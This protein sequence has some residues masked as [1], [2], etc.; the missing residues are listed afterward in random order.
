MATGGMGDVLSGIIAAL[1]AQG[2][3]LKCALQLACC[4]HAYAADIEAEK[5]GERG[6]TATDIIPTIRLLLNKIIQPKR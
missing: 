3:D 6:L 5:Q 1:V 2:Y 4:L